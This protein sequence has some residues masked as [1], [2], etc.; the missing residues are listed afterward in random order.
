VLF[1][2]GAGETIR[3]NLLERTN[4]H[5]ILRLPTGIFYAQGVKANVIF[6]DNKPAAKTPWTK[7][8]WIYDFRTNVH[9]TLKTNRLQKSD[10][11]EF[12]NLYKPD[13]IKKR[14][15]TWDD[16]KAEGRWRSYSYEEIV[17]RDKTNLDIFWLKDDTLED[18]ENLPAPEI[19][20]AEIVEQLEAALTEFRSVEEALVGNHN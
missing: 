3:K 11:E 6:F 1:E 8:L 15:D 4:L 13:D 10:F 20:A 7:K 14:K 18:T 12:I 17:A 9:M 16:Q 2:G 5:T 19:L